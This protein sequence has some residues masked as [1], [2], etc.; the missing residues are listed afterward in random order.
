MLAFAGKDV[1]MLGCVSYSR[2]GIPI[3][4]TVPFIE[5]CF[6]Y[7]NLAWDQFPRAL[8]PE[9]SENLGSMLG[10]LATILLS[11]SLRSSLTSLDSGCPFEMRWRSRETQRDT[12]ELTH[13][14]SC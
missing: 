2:C 13:K 8:G 10:T 14:A 4:E 9:S 6:I 3:L 12:F 5:C 1:G 11:T 7:K